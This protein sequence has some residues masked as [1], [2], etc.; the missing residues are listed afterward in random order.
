MHTGGEPL[1]IIVSGYPKIEGT[2]ILEKRKFAR[3]KCDHLRKMLVF[4]PRG[5]YDMYGAILVEPDIAGAD[6]GTLFIHNEGYSTMCGHAVIALGRFAVDYGYV[7][8]QEPETEVAVQCPCGLVKAFVEYNSKQ[9]KTGRVR[10]HSVPA[11]AFSLG[12]LCTIR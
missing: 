9:K 5:H 7:K 12:K 8:P 11:F 10:F 3:E 1:R 6:L 2:S 4:E